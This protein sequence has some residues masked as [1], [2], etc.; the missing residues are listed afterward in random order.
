MADDDV[1]RLLET[2]RVAHASR[3]KRRLATMMGGGRYAIAKEDEA[4]DIVQN[5]F[6]TIVCVG[7]GQREISV[8]RQAM[9]DHADDEY[10]LLDAIRPLFERLSHEISTIKRGTVWQRL[11]R[12]DAESALNS[13]RQLY[14]TSSEAIA[15]DY[16]L[17]AID[18]PNSARVIHNRVDDYHVES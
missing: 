2:K 4:R 14:F 13:D 11:T 18:D 1:R 12:T 5:R 15:E 3:A 6:G 17:R 9:A 7:Y 8:V 16:A 10:A